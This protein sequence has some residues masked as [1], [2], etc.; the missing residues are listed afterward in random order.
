[1]S[2]G[3]LDEELRTRIGRA[4]ATF[5][6]LF[7]IWR[8]KISLKTKLRIYN[9]VVISTLLYGS[10]TCATTI[11][12]EKRLDVFDNRCLRRIL[13]IKWFHRVRNT[14]VRERTGQIPASLLLKTRRLKWFGHV[15]RMGQE[16]LPKAL[17][18]WRLE[19]AKRRRG[20][21]RTR[22]KD[23]VERDARLAGLDQ[24]LESM[25]SDRA[26]WR[27]MLALLVS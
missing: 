13:G 16:R 8:S 10:E 25:A 1:M 2:S 26:Q 4:S 17:S 15:S 22:W 5:G 14:T 6:Q 27:D 11:S 20:R 19:N 24:E 23:A 9:A 21:C 3:R 7:K 12:E 18:Q